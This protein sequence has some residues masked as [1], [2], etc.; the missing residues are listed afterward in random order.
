[1]KGLRYL[2]LLLQRPGV[3]IPARELSDAVAGNI[4]REIADGS[5]IDRIDRRALA[6]YRNRLTEIDDEIAQAREWSDDG[7]LVALDAE[8]EAI[9]TEVRSATGLGGRVR[10]MPRDDER[11]R[12]AVRKAIAAAIERIA[13]V[14]ASLGRLLTDRVSTGA[15]CRYEPDPDRPVTWDLTAERVE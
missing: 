6:A 1:M 3:D 10:A 14:D 5:P 4:G 11:A 15:Q 13:E 12:V 8:R 9:L 2:R 7:R